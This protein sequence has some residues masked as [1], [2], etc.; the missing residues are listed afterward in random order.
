MLKIK[1]PKDLENEY[2]EI[3]SEYGKI[4][5]DWKKYNDEIIPEDKDFAKRIIRF[6]IQVIEY[7]IKNY[8]KLDI[9]KYQEFLAYYDFEFLYGYHGDDQCY[10]SFDETLNGK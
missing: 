1:L 3:N 6:I 5:D 8:E 7:T 4:R 2:Y 9:Q 10:L